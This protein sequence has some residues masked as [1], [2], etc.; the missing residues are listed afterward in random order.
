MR[1]FLKNKKNVYEKHIKFGQK[2]IGEKGLVMQGN[3]EVDSQHLASE[4]KLQ[5]RE[6]QET[7]ESLP[8]SV[9]LH[10][11]DLMKKVVEENVNPST[12]S[13]ACKC[14][15]EIHKMIKINLDLKR[16]GL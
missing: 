4:T 6:D 8:K 10:L 12:V 13:A 16:S 2:T 3:G 9:S 7:S 5:K 15:S 1:F 11:L 14:A